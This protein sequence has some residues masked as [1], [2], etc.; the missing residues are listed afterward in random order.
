MD[1]SAGGVEVVF[2][3]R[4]I[5]FDRGGDIVTW[6]RKLVTSVYQ[7][8]VTIVYVHTVDIGSIHRV[9]RCLE[10]YDRV[11]IMTRE[12][13]LRYFEVALYDI[14]CTYCRRSTCRCSVD[15]Y[16]V[17]GEL[18]LV[19]GDDP[20]LFL[21]FADSEISLIL[22]FEEVVFYFLRVLITD[23]PTKLSV[24][25]WED[26]CVLECLIQFLCYFVHKRTL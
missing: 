6:S 7:D 24:F 14:V 21:F 10:C 3:Y 17:E 23:H 4:T 15:R 11:Y 16:L 1:L 2:F 18:R 12:Y 9:A 5:S 25:E 22:E 8:I 19:I 26:F 13:P 20:H